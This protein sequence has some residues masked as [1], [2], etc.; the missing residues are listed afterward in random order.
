MSETR[1]QRGTWRGQGLASAMKKLPPELIRVTLTG[2]G[3]RWQDIGQ[4]TGLIF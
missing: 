4:S 2:R 1:L 3:V